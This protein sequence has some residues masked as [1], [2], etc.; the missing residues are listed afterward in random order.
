MQGCNVIEAAA[1]P[2]GIGTEA[3]SPGI[4]T[5]ASALRGWSGRGKGHVSSGWVVGA[6][7]NYQRLWGISIR[8]VH[9][10]N[11]ALRSGQGNRGAILLCLRTGHPLNLR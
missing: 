1:E 9:D 7:C 6:A 2:I 10:G 3:K 5:R 8:S 11:G 4:V